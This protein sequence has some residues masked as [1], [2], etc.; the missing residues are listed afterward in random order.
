MANKPSSNT[1]VDPKEF[2]R[3]QFM[4]DRFVEYSKWSIVGIAGILLLMAIFLL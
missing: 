2:E 3:A 1:D 4:W